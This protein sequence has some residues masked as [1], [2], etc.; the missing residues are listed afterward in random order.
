MITEQN[1]EIVYD[2]P[3]DGNCQ[4]SALAFALAHIGIFRSAQ[5]LREDVIRYLRAHH[6][7]PEGSRIQDFLSID[8]DQYIRSMSRNGAYGNE[9]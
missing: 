8:L 3:P 1:Y 5:T 7:I 6:R 4:L 2:P 9:H